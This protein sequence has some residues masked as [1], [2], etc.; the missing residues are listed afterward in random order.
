MSPV[1]DALELTDLLASPE[2]LANTTRDFANGG[3][4]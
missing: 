2:A 4:A 3:D 1:A